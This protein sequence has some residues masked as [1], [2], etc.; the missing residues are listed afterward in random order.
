[1]R[2]PDPYNCLVVS[3]SSGVAVVLCGLFAWSNFDYRYSAGVKI[4]LI[5]GGLLAVMCLVSFAL[6]A[7]TTL[8]R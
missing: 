4:F 7:W 5:L 8:R 6:F 2:R 3:Q 1:M